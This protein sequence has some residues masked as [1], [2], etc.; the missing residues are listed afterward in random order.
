MTKN[1]EYNSQRENLVISEYGRHVQNLIRHAKT[2]E[3]K[4][5]RQRFIE[6]VID[7]MYQMNPQA[8]NLSEVKEKLWK[9]AFR[10]SGYDLDVTPP[11]GILLSQADIELKPETID[12]PKHVRKNRHYGSYIQEM[13]DKA[14]ALDDVEKQKEFFALIASYMKLAYKTWNK[15]H[16]ANDETIKEDLKKMTNRK[17]DFIDELSLDL[18][19][20]SP[21][22][23]AN[24]RKYKSKSSNNNKKSKSV[25]RRRRRR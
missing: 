12:Y 6:G 11:E 18:L 24:S 21:A 8:K 4:D 15:E 10:I 20:I 17:F 14:I 13:I 25:R 2:I 7:L 16:Y 1:I 9:H 19:N 23:K 5:E 22:L 3:D